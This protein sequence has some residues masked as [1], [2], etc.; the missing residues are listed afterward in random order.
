M[1]MVTTLAPSCSSAKV[2]T[3]VRHA[4]R[5]A[6]GAPA[7]AVRPTNNTRAAARSGVRAS[8]EATGS[9]AAAS[10]AVEA[11]AADTD[12]PPRR[13]IER[14]I[15]LAAE[16]LTAE[17]F[18]PFGQVVSVEEDGV[19]FGEGDARLDLAQG[20]PRFYIMRLRDKDLSFERITFHHCVTQCLGALGE[21]SWYMAGRA[22]PSFTLHCPPSF[23]D[24]LNLSAPWTVGS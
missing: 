4:T 3:L 10:A 2:G 17:A 14:R 5:R 23:S 6:S 20:T 9:A 21:T 22:G 15:Q 19:P 7:P 24:S 12:D 1:A 8:A 13:A 16:E 18:A 11:S